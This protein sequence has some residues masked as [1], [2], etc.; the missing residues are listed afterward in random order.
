MKIEDIFKSCFLNLTHQGT[1]SAL[2]F[3]IQGYMLSLMNEVDRCV[4]S[5]VGFV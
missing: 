5:A 4:A 1:L 3:R 2:C